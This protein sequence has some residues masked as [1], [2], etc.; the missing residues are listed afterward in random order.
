MKK[1]ILSASSAIKS[2]TLVAS[3][4]AF[5]SPAH[6]SLTPAPIL[7]FSNFS[8][9]SANTGPLVGGPVFNYGD[10]H[11]SNYHWVDS[12]VTTFRDVTTPAKIGIAGSVDIF[13]DITTVT[14]TEKLSYYDDRASYRLQ[15][16]SANYASGQWIKM[17]GTIAAA[18]DTYF[19][20]SLNATGNYLTT[21]IPGI[22]ELNPALPSL[23]VGF[24]SS[25][26]AV[27]TSSNTVPGT[28][29][30]QYAVS[31]NNYGYSKL[32][33][34]GTSTSFAAIIYTSGNVS[35]DQF[36]LNIYGSS[37]GNQDILTPKT[38]IQSTLFKSV[39]ISAL[40][41]A[42]VPVPAAVWL[43]GTGLLG[44]TGFARKRKAG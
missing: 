22:G 3:M 37:Y 2:I 9:T 14:T 39:A 25:L 26:A 42:A 10:Y 20:L 35:L 30:N 17:T 28:S 27:T 7:T 38:D 24:D 41:I 15:G 44:L 21:S 36:W 13:K 43:F 8:L 16:D 11:S 32:L 40:P 4:A 18:Q 12:Q 29:S 23:F 34:A 33:V 1:Q 31:Y 19:D 5:V 6:A